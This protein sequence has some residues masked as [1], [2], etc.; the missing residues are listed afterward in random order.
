LPWLRVGIDE[1]GKIMVGKI[2]KRR[3]RAGKLA[4]IYACPEFSLPLG[5]NSQSSCQTSL[6][7]INQP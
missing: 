2:M 7:E 5:W 6:R 3:I 1:F 4:E